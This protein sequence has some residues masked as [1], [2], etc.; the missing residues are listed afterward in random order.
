MALWKAR[1]LDALGR[2][3]K[4]TAGDTLQQRMDLQTPVQ[5]VLDISRLSAL[6]SGVGDE[7]G[8]FIVDMLDPCAAASSHWQEQ[9]LYPILG[10]SGFNLPDVERDYRIWIMA[11]SSYCDAGET[12]KI[13]RWGAGVSMDGTKMRLNSTGEDPVFMLAGGIG[14]PALSYPLIKSFD[15][16]GWDLLPTCAV[17]GEGTV[18]LTPLPLYIPPPAKL[19][20]LCQTSAAMGAPGIMTIFLC[21]AGVKGTTPPGMG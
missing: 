10:A 17:D 8:F 13:T 12:S 20:T 3:F 21:W 15:G 6:G 7:C 11:V 5:P 14:Q 9:L 19:G 4:F 18:S 16:S 2:I 1:T